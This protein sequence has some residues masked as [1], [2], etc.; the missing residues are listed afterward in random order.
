[1]TAAAGL[2]ML[3]WAAWYLPELPLRL[4]EPV[5]FGDAGEQAGVE[6]HARCH[7]TMQCYS[8]ADLPS[9]LEVTS[10]YTG[11]MACGVPRAGVLLATRT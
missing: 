10:P 2:A 11:A 4:R 6:Q 1:M 3:C 9:E 7:R 5:H 8:C